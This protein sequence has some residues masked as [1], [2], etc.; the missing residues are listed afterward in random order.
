MATDRDTTM[1]T[2]VTT[3]YQEP[4]VHIHSTDDE[5]LRRISHNDP[6]VAGLAVRFVGIVDMEW[7]D[8]IG[9]AI[10]NSIHLR[11]LDISY[12][13][14]SACRSEQMELFF[15]HLAHNRSIEHLTVDSI[16]NSAVDIF[17][18][19][20]PFFEQNH[21]FRCIKTIGGCF[22]M[23]SFISA[24]ERPK[25]NRL[26]RIDLSGNEIG[27]EVLPDLINALTVMPGLNILSELSLGFN[28]IKN[29]GCKKLG[30]LLKNTSSG[31]QCLDLQHN[32]M[33]DTGIGF[34]LA[35]F[36]ENAT[37]RSLNLSSQRKLRAESWR[38]L[39]AYLRSPNCLLETL[40]LGAESHIR[41]LSRK[42]PRRQQHIE[43]HELRM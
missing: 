30:E 20:A 39:S 18:I 36:L 1:T 15:R 2:P 19:L 14:A 7:V 8:R 5:T 28:R 11:R 32:F 13:S 29:E 38:M 21:N 24:L 42:C 4:N 37:L 26:E 23:I 40:Y 16:D 3:G 12:W 10:S 41:F 9:S 35:G 31:I 22:S 34:L 33:D 25:A 27:D 17:A 43:M 6:D